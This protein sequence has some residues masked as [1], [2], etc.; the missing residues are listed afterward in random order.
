MVVG[1]ASVCEEAWTAFLTS[2][3]A[4]CGLIVPSDGI[5]GSNQLASCQEESVMQ[6]KQS[7]GSCTSHK[8]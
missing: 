7:F 8:F 4:A 1:P 5:Y 6:P 3:H 2:H